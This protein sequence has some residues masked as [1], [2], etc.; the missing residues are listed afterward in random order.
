MTAE[1]EQLD[2]VIEA[3]R[4]KLIDFFDEGAPHYTIDMDRGLV[5]ETYDFGQVPSTCGSAG[6]IAGAAFTMWLQTID[7]ARRATTVKRAQ[8]TQSHDSDE[9]PQF[10]YDYQ[11]VRD[12][13]LEFLGLPLTDHAGP[14]QYGHPLFSSE[15]APR[16]CTAADAA[17]ALR[18]TFEGKDPWGTDG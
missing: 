1:N 7:P 14:L 6:C 5:T 18:R 15:M 13:A 16:G 11:T 10:E 8:I 2:I 17:R 4:R 3:N 9:D 12:G